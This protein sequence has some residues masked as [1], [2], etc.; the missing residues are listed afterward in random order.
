MKYLY[1]EYNYS[2]N[3]FAYNLS[4]NQIEITLMINDE[5]L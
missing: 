1:D 4:N 3:L 2:Y 5:I